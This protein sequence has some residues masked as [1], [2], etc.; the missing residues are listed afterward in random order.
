V[1]LITAGAAAGKYVYA[2]RKNKINIID[3]DNHDNTKDS[4]EENK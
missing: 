2:L 1:I 3:N 4:K